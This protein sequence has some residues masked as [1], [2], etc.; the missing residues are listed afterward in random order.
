MTPS[1][2]EDHISQIPALQLLQNFGYTYLTPE[3]TLQLRGGRLNAVLLEDVLVQQLRRLNRIRFKGKEYPF[4][5]G[6][7]LSAIQTLKDTLYDGLVRTNEK[8]YDLLC[9]GKSLQ[10]SIEGDTKSFPLNYIDWN[11]ETWLTNNVFHVTE[12]FSVERTGSHETRR[13]DVVL[14]VNGIPLAV[15]ECKRPDIK[16]PIGEA[17]SQHLRNQRE[18]EIPKLF[19]FTQLLLAIS[20]NEAKYATVGTPAKFWSVWKEQDE[21]EEKLKALKN[22][23]LSYEQKERL[24]GERFDYVRS[25]FDAMDAADRQVTEQ[26]RALYDLARPERLL[27]LTYRYTLFDAGEKKVARYQQYFCV[28]KILDRIRKLQKDG[29]RQGGIV[30]HTQGSGKS[31][32]MVMLAMGI[33]LESSI[34]DYKVLLATDRLDLD[35]QIFKTFKHCGVDPVQARTGAHLSELL[36]GSK[37]QII[38]TVI[39]KFDAA[40]G[41]GSKPARNTNKHALNV[42]ENNRA[43]LEPAP[44][45]VGK[46]ARNDNPNIFVLVDEG[47]RGQFGELH[48]KMRKALPNACFI[49]FT[50]T[51]ILK[52]TKNT[53]ERFGGLIDTYTISQAV[54][55]KAVVPL[56]YEGRH[57]DQ[58][59]DSESIDAWFDRITE[60]LTKE[61]RAD[62]K[63][64]F[65]TTDQLNKAEKKIMR[66]A[67][68]ISTHFRDNWQGTPYKAQLVTQDKSTALLYK[69]YLD[70]FAMVSS[71]V[72]ISPPDDRE[73]NTEVEEENPQAVQI[74]WKKMMARFGSEKE[75]NR[76]IIN[77]FKKSDHPEIIIVVDKLLTGFDAPRNTVLYLTRKLKD[78]T[79]LQAIAR[80]N[81][82]Y[83]GKDF[84]YI[85]DY[86]GVLQNLDEA[87]DVYGKL[88]DF[89]EEGLEDLCS[90]LLDVSEEVKKLAQRHSDLWNLFK[91]VKNKQD[92]EAYE[93]HLADEELRT[94]FYERLSAYSRTLAIALASVKFIETAP[95]K[96]V[97]QYKDDLSFFMKLRTAV[98]RRYAEVVD[99][100]EY[101]ERIQKLLDTHVGTGEVERVTNLVNIFD[102]EAF[103]KELDQLGNAASKADTIAH[104]TQKTIHERME[105][106]PTFYKRF[107]ELLEAAIR[108]FREQ[109]LSDLEYLKQVTEIADKV[110]NRTGDDIP[111]QLNHRDVA[112]AFYGVLLEVFTKYAKEGLDMRSTS[113]DA[114][115]KV[116]EIV[117]EHRIVNW[118]NNVDIQNRM[119]NAIEDYLFELKKEQG[120]NLAFEDI[121]RILELCLEIARIRY[122]S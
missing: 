26:D 8:I 115:L 37:S 18:D 22:K 83:D 91:D 61:Q 53:V 36:L 73:G 118:I 54:N 97:K 12:E 58:T 104:R 108:A 101:E 51:P 88:A 33:A 87:L 111:A 107:S 81:R 44:T 9:L 39:N 15:I 63:K 117:N 102:T 56:L 41:A 40:V 109:R 65:T 92:E 112:K 11:P 49:G 32:T 74:F 57:V 114:G 7:I 110:R 31:L 98:R 13:P 105:E 76:Q 10:Q 116:D 113:A 25:Y 27:E 67:W 82:L 96:K 68:D 122:P 66:I 99:F 21:K 6:N 71:D 103:N 55:D 95:E 78:H 90:A 4:S 52:K 17:I 64:K 69:K 77:S 60:T 86:R 38:T 94:K 121:D 23:P 59:V 43:G 50:G 28:Q 75:Y 84:G 48:A 42:A 62:L 46:P 45:N 14:F 1:F 72:L 16:D 100:K 119:R 93:R 20:A 120:I 80:V 5:E 3:E 19:L 47:H 35:D 34:E 85:I 79:L 89:D 24:F 106:D 2:K 29:T 30:W 70:E